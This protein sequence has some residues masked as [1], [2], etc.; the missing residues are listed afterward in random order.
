MT[1]LCV[2]CS[3][4]PA[5]WDTASVLPEA[6]AELE[7]HEYMPFLNI[8]SIISV[9]YEQHERVRTKRNSSPDVQNPYLGMERRQDT[10]YVKG[11]SPKLGT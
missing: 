4:D 1:E 2:S 5:C 8:S 6:P 11:H 10:I 3:C 9:I 7:T